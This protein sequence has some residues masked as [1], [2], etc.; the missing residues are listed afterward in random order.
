M[1]FATHPAGGS[2][3][4]NAPPPVSHPGARPLLLTLL[5]LISAAGIFF[6]KSTQI[7]CLALA[8]SLAT[9]K[10]CKRKIL[11]WPHISIWLFVIL[12]SLLVPNGKVL[13][14]VLVYSIT[15][16]ALFAGI[17][18]A[19]KLSAVS[20]LSQC[21]V[22]L[23]PKE[24]SLLALTLDYYKNMSDNFRMTQGPLFVRL[25]A[26]ISIQENEEP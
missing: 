21:A 6:I 22:M 2:A 7:L 4:R 26:A 8:L 19:L 1:S 9:Q 13:C 25:K 15:E 14:T 23:K 17:Q 10:L 12:T 3:P 5:L 11:I 20:A 16:G 24:N 18:K